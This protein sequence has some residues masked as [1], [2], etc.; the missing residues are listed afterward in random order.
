PPERLANAA[1]LGELALDGALRGVRGTLSL[2]E[3]L[4]RAGAS[5]LL[6]AAAAAPEA[7]LV[8]GLEGLPVACLGDAVHWL[9]GGEPA[10]A[11]PA[12]REEGGARGG[13]PAGGRGG[14][15]RRRALGTAAAGGHPPLRGAPRGAAKPPP[16][17][18]MPGIPPPLDPDE[19][20][21]ATRLHSVAGLRLPGRGLMRG[22]P[23]R[24]PHHSV[25][26]AGLV[27]GGTPLRPGELSL[28]HHGVLFL[29]ELSACPRLP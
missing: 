9:R 19:A 2:A 23:F 4:W 17:R 20:L 14:A 5:T 13:V 7:A 15:V 26:R 11:A 28:A 3:A 10:R 29:D 24:A 22:R 16:A 8:Q 27:G 1:A 25:T 18:L 21:T 12:R 6:C